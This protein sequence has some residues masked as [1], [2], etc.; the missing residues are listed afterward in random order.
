M[1]AI[2]AKRLPLTVEQVLGLV[3]AGLLHPD[4]PAQLLDGQLFHMTPQGPEHAWS[5]TRIADL[6]RP[7]LPA[8]MRVLEEKPLLVDDH[9]LPEPDVAVVPRAS[10][11][12]TS[13]PKASDAVLVVEV[14]KTSQSIDRSK[15]VIYASGGAPRYW[16]VDLVARTITVYSEPSA[17][18][19]AQ[20]R[21]CRGTDAL[22][23]PDG[24]AATVAELLG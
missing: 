19:Y 23:L 2:P 7:R 22:S 17:D 14:S 12:P 13:H 10:R 21:T 16:H 3:E 18:G 24:T 5:V 6:L 1:S 8:T 4:E 11:G 20:M 15:A 9:N